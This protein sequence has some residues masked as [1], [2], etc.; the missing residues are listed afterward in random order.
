LYPNSK[1]VQRIVTHWMAP[2][3]QIHQWGFTHN[4]MVSGL[5]HIHPLYPQ[6]LQSS[7]I[8]PNRIE[9]ILCSI[10]DSV[11]YDFSK[12]ESHL[13]P[14]VAVV[15]P[16]RYKSS[17]FPGKPL[18]KIKGKEMIIWVAEI[19]E[20]A[21]GRD[22][23]YI[24]TENEEIV[25]VVKGNGY[26]VVLTSDSC[27]T[28]TDRVAEAAL[29]IDAD[30]IINIQGDEPMLNPSDITKVIQE[31]IKHPNHV[32][33]CMAY[34]SDGENVEDKKIPK[35][36]TS[37]TDELI[38]ISRNPIPGTKTGNGAAPKKQVCIYGFNRNELKKFSDMGEK[39][40]L[41]F[42]EDIEII[43]FIEMGVKVKMVMLNSQSYAVDYPEDINIVERNL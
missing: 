27:P 31:K 36:I 7:I 20:K 16:A 40:P 38:Y 14:K 1:Q 30:I 26:K 15:I 13:I 12:I 22:N 21:V 3:Q 19:A 6:E 4:Y 35:V 41:E 29:E 33:N 8:S 37:L 43:R 11:S 17:R 24:A 28:G 10:E 42:E 25:D 9:D 23:V 39:T 34:L 18:A 5:N 2:L 32:I